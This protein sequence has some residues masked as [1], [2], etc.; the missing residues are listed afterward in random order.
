VRSTNLKKIMEKTDKFGGLS[1]RN[2]ERDM[3][4]A[5]NDSGQDQGNDE[6][7]KTPEDSGTITI[8]KEALNE[9][10]ASAVATHLKATEAERRQAR[11]ARGKQIIQLE[12]DE[13]AKA[14]RQKEKER[15]DT[16]LVQLQEE[17]KRMREKVEAG[18]RPPRRI[19]LQPKSSR[20][21][22]LRGF[23]ALT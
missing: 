7:P 14:K 17:M 16:L 12:E 3:E 5:G 11:E 19:P 8:T 9:M 21:D 4:K 1:P 20:R 6:S 2:L 23:A 22:C 10:I 18:Q 15:V 13:E